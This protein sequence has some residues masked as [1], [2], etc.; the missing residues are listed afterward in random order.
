M[1]RYPENFSIKINDEQK[2]LAMTYNFK[3]LKGIDEAQLKELLNKLKS[4]PLGMFLRQNV[5]FRDHWILLI[6]IDGN[7][8][9][10]LSDN[11][12]LRLK[13]WIYYEVYEEKLWIVD[14]YWKKIYSFE[15]DF[16]PVMD[17]ISEGS[18]SDNIIE[19]INFQNDKGMV[20]EEVV[21]FVDFLQKKKIC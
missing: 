12:D 3:Y 6:P 20:N 10:R 15:K 4:E 1:A 16:K 19:R 9:N 14:M 8:R 2:E 17:L 7:I 5:I 18:T 11:E 13:P 21:E